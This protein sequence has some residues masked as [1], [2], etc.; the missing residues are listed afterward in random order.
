LKKANKELREI[1]NTIVCIGGP[2]ND[3]NLQFNKDQLKYINQ[4][5][6]LL[7]GVKEILDGN[8][9]EVWM[10]IRFLPGLNVFIIDKDQE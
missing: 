7:Q 9:R 6:E 4:L 3:N 10:K 8:S 2:L 5:Y 1:I